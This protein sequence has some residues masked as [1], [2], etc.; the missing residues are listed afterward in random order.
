MNS[1]SVILATAAL[2]MSGGLGFA[3]QQYDSLGSPTPAPNQTASPNSTNPN[4]PMPSTTGNSVGSTTS[5]TSAGRGAE[6]IGENKKVPAGDLNGGT[7]GNVNTGITTPTDP[8]AT[9]GGS[10]FYVVQDVT[11]KKCLVIDKP[12]ANAE[13]KLM[14]EEKPFTTRESAEAAMK[15][16]QQCAS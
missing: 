11:T 12:V 3:Q 1:R 16:I 5:G 4:I 13:A 8:T 9:Q 6:T 2:L 14:T 15:Q 10:E 7:Y